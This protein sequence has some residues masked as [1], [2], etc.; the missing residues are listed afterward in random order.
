MKTAKSVISNIVLMALFCIPAL[1]WAQNISLNS[2]FDSDNRQS[3]V[4]R[5]NDA[6][7]EGQMEICRVV[8][9]RTVQLEAGNTAK[10]IATGAGGILG[11]AIGSRSANGMTPEATLGAIFGAVVA[12]AAV[13]KISSS[14]GQEFFLNCNGRATTVVQEADG[15]PLPERGTEVFIQRVGGRSR[16][17]I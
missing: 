17:V 11:G 6:M 10:A 13:N 2:V 16:V 7:N 12:N 1:S 9:A 14:E 5:R 8:K 4:Y 3:G 15:T